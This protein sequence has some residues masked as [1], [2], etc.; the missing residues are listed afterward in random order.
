MG[1][2]AQVARALA[3]NRFK[4]ISGDVPKVST[5]R[6]AE[7]ALKHCRRTKSYCAS[8]MFSDVAGNNTFPKET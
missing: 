2:D 3:R 7:T 1:D 8:L 5:G 6:A 4:N